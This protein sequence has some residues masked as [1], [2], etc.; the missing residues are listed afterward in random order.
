VVAGRTGTK[1]F[2]VYGR[3]AGKK[4]KRVKTKL[5]IF[6]Q[7]RDDRHRWTVELARIEARKVLGRLAMGENPN[8]VP[9]GKQ[10]PSWRTSTRFSH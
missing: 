7:P 9:E 5:G 10:A 1:T 3:V 4:G 8:A 2:V 6:G